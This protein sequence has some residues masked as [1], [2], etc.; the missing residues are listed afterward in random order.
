MER[1]AG[2]IVVR[3]IDGDPHVLGLQ[4]RNGYDL[5]KGHIEK[6]ESDLS[7]ALR[8]TEEEASISVVRFLWGRESV[9]FRTKQGK[10]V[11]LFLATT[12]QEPSIR[13]NPIS[14]KY[15][16]YGMKWLSL[17]EAESQLYPYLRPSISW[18]RS[19]LAAVESVV[20]FIRHSVTLQTE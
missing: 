15:E 9:K 7:A 12:D 10:E 5:P 11:T 1:S 20:E 17:A 13:K 6:G 4:G 19:R 8:E 2:I 18:V 3:M 16:H 14:G